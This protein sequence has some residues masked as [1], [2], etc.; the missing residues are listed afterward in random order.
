[1][2]LRSWAKARR[3]HEILLPL[4]EGSGNRKGVTTGGQNQYERIG[5]MKEEVI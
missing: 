2:D 1:M 5:N 4:P 3:E